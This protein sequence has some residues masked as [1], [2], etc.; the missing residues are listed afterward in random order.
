MG[1]MGYMKICQLVQKLF[2]ETDI[3]TSWYQEP[4][5]PYKPEMK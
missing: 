5:L 1:G 2:G 3:L 4:A